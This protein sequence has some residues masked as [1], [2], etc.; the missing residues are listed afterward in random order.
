METEDTEI[1]AGKSQI[2]NWETNI[3]AGE[4]GNKLRQNNQNY[5]RKHYIS[6]RFFHNILYGRINEWMDHRISSNCT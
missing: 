3:G 2:R 4:E 5:V 6:L 1:H